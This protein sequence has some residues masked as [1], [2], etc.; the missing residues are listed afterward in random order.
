M[1]KIVTLGTLREDIVVGYDF[2]DSMQE[3]E[4]KI[5]K[6]DKIVGGSV[7]NTSYYLAHK[8]IETQV[9]MCSLYYVYLVEIMRKRINCAN[10]QISTTSNE[11]IRY[12]VSII[13][14]KNNGDKQMISYNPVV[15]DSLLLDLFNKESN[16]A[17]L[18]YTSFYEVNQKNSKKLFALFSNVIASGKNVMI[19]LCPLLNRIH[20]DEIENILSSITVLSGNES[21]YEMLKRIIGLNS[22]RDIFTKFIS[23]EKIYV[24]R[25][26]KGATLFW[27]DEQNKIHE[28]QVVA[29]LGNIIKNTTGC[30]DVFNAVIIEGIVNNRDLKES[31]ECAVNESGKIAEGGL[32]W[33]KG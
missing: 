32:P 6:F 21:E 14:V 22:I 11:L 26:D 9:V 3:A 2:S 16:N 5:D 19:D 20:N 7:N 27:S 15:D 25:G 12:P 1:K 33:I 10:Y 17:E 18:I 31:L 28:V 23:I 4:K 29:K 13:G 30:G 24:K 8:D